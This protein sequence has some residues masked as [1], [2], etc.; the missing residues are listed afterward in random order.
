[1]CVLQKS[2]RRESVT[3]QACDKAADAAG[4]GTSELK[5]AGQ[6]MKDKAASTAEDVSVTTFTTNLI[7][8]MSPLFFRDVKTS[9]PAPRPAQG[10][11]RP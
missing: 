4:Q 11:W 1:M 8:F 6:E 7:F 10:I 3:T 2:V 5:M 9:L